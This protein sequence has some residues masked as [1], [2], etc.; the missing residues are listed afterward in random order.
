MQ[1]WERVLDCLAQALNPK[2]LTDWFEPLKPV[3]EENGGLWIQTP[4]PFFRD[5]IEGHFRTPL[6][7]AMK[8]AGEG[9]TQL[10]L[11]TAQEWNE[12]GR[13]A[14]K[15]ASETPAAAAAPRIQEELPF[16]PDLNPKYTLES[17]VVGGSNQ[18]AHAAAK[19]VSE[20]LGRSYNPLF[21][22][23]GVGLGKTHLL[24]AIGNYTLAHHPGRKV[25]YTSTERF[26]NEMVA[27]ITHSR[28]AQFNARYRHV[29]LLLIDD[30]QFLAGK[31]RTM[32]EFFHTFN[33]LHGSGKQ[34][35]IS[36]DRAPKELKDLEERLRS[37]FE[38]GLIADIQPPDFETKVAI[39]HK[40]AELDSL[41]LP[42]DV[43]LYIGTHCKN[44]VRELEGCLL[45]LSAFAS[46]QGRPVTM[47]LA[48]DAFRD[49][50][51]RPEDRRVT[52]DTIQR[53]VAGV[54]KLSTRELLSRTN[55]HT[56]VQPRQVAMYLCHKLAG[57]SLPET[58]RRFGG[59]HHSTVLHS[60]SK[61]E[62]RMAAEPDFHKLIHSIIEALQ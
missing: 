19:A 18:F 57:A 1:R 53:H 61:V 58:G 29:D 60:I 44:N 50:F 10:H 36:S 23:G 62:D 43:A 21:I 54:F 52:I 7:H 35:V 46:L 37:R 16:K 48:R 51:V 32:E 11:V 13:A 2:D 8:E 12:K 38:W 25:I 40:K 39:L 15:A 27:A 31:E 42:D 4:N 47:E 56:V 3:R 9:N 14:R 41:A 30:I 33:D 6:A 17:F 26:L 49:Q 24:Q 45:R 22:Y 34:V 55:K 28:M 5:H 59:K 20:D